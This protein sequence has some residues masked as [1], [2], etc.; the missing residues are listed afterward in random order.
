MKFENLQST[1][2]MLIDEDNDAKLKELRRSMMPLFSYLD[3]RLRGQVSR[4][5]IPIA[6]IKLGIV[7]KDAELAKRDFGWR[8]MVGYDEFEKIICSYVG[9]KV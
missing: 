9:I 5:S 2:N 8:D 4:S 6:L 1:R 3:T 7:P